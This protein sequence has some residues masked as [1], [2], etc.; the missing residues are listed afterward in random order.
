MV[1][2]PLSRQNPSGS[3]SDTRSQADITAG[4][5]PKILMAAHTAAASIL[6][7]EHT[8][9]KSGQGESFWQFREYAQH[10]RPQDID[11]R[12][13]AKTDRVYV[14]EKEQQSSQTLMV[15]VNDGEG[16]NWRSSNNIPTKR[17][18]SE[19]IALAISIIASRSGEMFRLLQ[20][21]TRPARTDKAIE[22]LASTLFEG[23]Q[24]DTAL[25]TL[26]SCFVPERSI[27]VVIGDFLFPVDILNT[28]LSGFAEK[29]E[30]GAIVQVLDP[31]ELSLPYQ[32]RV[33]FT[34]ADGGGREIVEN[35]SSIRQT[36][37][38]RFSAH[39]IAI[40]DLARKYGWAYYQT[41]TD[42]SL[43]SLVQSLWMALALDTKN[44]DI[45]GIDR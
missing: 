10:D 31:A 16:M 20:P 6:A 25:E 42:Q 2:V 35:V 14:R 24:H 3:A 21:G 13:S 4:D 33:E 30:N 36:Y 5:V 11:W 40:R 28:A 1:K 22:D 41:A 18:M 32:G 19:V 15:W 43:T 37:Q 26:L 39:N 38:D 12:Q 29:C 7:G 34:S 17:M 8:R 27:P 23:R 9:K 44:K 45:G